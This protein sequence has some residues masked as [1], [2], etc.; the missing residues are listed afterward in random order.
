M[1][2]RTD[3]ESILI[4]G[5]GPIVIGQA[6]EFD[7]SGAQACKALKQ[8]G[9]KVILVN[10]NPA[11]IMTDPEMADVTYIEPITWQVLERVIAKERPHAILPTMGGQTAL[12]CA[13]DLHRHGVLAKY[14]V[15]LIGARP[16]AIEKAEDRQKFKEA[17][18]RIG[19][20]S[21]RSAIAHSLAEAQAVQ[22]E[23]GFPV[24]IRPSFTLGGSGGGVA[25]NT[26]EFAAI[27]TR[28]LD[29]S[30]TRELLIEESL[31]GWKE[32]E[33]E[34]VR[35]RADNCIIVCS[36]ENLDPMGIHTGDSITVAPAQ[37]LTDKEY[38]LMRDASIAILREI[39]VDTGGS[40]VQFAINPRDGRMVV[41]EMNPRV[42]RS[43]ALASKATGF[44][45][46]KVA[47]KLAV[48]YTLDELA[49]EITGGAT[50][51]SFEPTI[52]YVVTKV[53]R[54]AFEKFREADPRLTTQMK[55]VGEVMAIGRTFQES[56]QKALRGLEVGVD[57]L[58]ERST[59][60]DE[61]VREIGEPGP[62]RIWFVADAFRIGMTVP[63]VHEE[64]GID[65]WFLAQIEELVQIERQLRGR[66]LASLAAAELRYL[67]RKGF[68]D[69]RLA[70]LLATDAAAVR[71]AR[72]RHGVR[73]VYKRVDTC[74][75]E[76]ATT[77]AYLY[78]TYE[79][80][81]E[82]DPSDRKKVMVLGGG[83]NRIG[84]GIEFD[85]CCVHAALALREDGYETIMV[86]CNPETVS[87]D[88]DT[89]D[90]L[91]FEPLTLEDVL[92]IVDKEKPA[93]VIVQ[94][95]GQTPLKLARDLE[96]AGVPIVGTS[97][98]SIDIAEDRERFQQLLMRLGLKQPP[99]RT[100]RTEAE[101]LALAEEIGYPLVVRPSYVLGG[102][103]MEI[104]Q[105]SRDLERYMREAVQVS[106]DAPVLLDRFLDD[107]IEVDVDCVA[108][109]REV[110][111]GGVMEHIEQ[112]GVHSGDSAC[113]LPPYSLAPAVVDELKRQTVRMAEALN[114][115]GLMNVQFAVQ[116][117]AVYVLEVNPRASRTVP[118]VSKATGV[119]L[120]KI[121][122]RCMLGR[123]LA[124]QGVRVEVVPPYFSVKEA[125]FPFAKFPGVD[126]LLG[127]EMRSTGE[128][129]GVGRTFGEALFK[130]QLAAGN[131]LPPSGT[132]FLSVK[133]SDKPRTVEVARMLYEMGYRLV[134]TRGTAAAIAAAGIPV[135]PVN[136]VKEGRPHVVDL[137]KNGEIDL[138]ITTVAEN[139]AQIADSR[140]IRTTALAQRVTY[141]TT[142]AGGRAA[143]EGMK[144][145]DRLEVY[146]L[147]SLH[148]ALA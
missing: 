90:R 144:H 25:W 137:L 49:N 7:Y 27:C 133:D 124:Q 114:V 110:R 78:S 53:P 127:P 67:K 8:E 86:N 83:P 6:C 76:F 65:P 148:R 39:G 60:A 111:I 77:T 108:D 63:Q 69:R 41:I 38:Q 132:V 28:G 11:T 122:A 48:G 43:S 44:P 82:A 10:S 119:P 30:P 145:L 61:I 87:T 55:S 56:F 2:K 139:R 138:V 33:M 146:D 107:A 98:D 120:A 72:L 134:A 12:N 66:A 46:A 59:D 142:I 64:T 80:E 102:R 118:F 84:Q 104:V 51:A 123:T 126:T 116:D 57:G 113:S 129:M 68:S 100:A 1:P 23:L 15:E 73:P 32:F 24:V 75:A 89:S 147:Q 115:C 81:C 97:P 91:Y 13:M 125:V 21:A 22:A 109:G 31:L 47:A 71:A 136:K 117:G 58:D 94:F 45:I 37:T 5:A 74:A 40:N 143:V 141:Y 112:A 135:R 106:N 95:G 34:V 52:D 131:T 101:A 42:S 92:E 14:G 26:E 70:K 99:N 50:P 105:D 130:S 93:G 96:A 88:Y 128:V 19:L 35:D 36:I 17:M 54:F 20:A 3:I 121:A 85:Y 140:S 62:H 103:A 29:L 79:E 16:Q 9:Y 18:T 4:I